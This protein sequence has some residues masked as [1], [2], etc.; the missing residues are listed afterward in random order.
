MNVTHKLYIDLTSRGDAPS[1]DVVQEEKYS[2]TL[3]LGLRE[4]SS[5]WCPP[6]DAAVI[7]RYR[8]PDGTGGAYDTLPDGTG[9]YSIS[10]NRVCVALAP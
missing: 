4:G 6:E 5:L 7:V 1:V 9:A 3:E 2:R 8:K 10:G